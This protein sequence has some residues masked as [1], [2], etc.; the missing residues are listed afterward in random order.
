MP[1]AELER[2]LR[3]LGVE[4]E[5]PA[6]PQL[7]QSVTRHLADAGVESR[8]PRLGWRPL[9]ARTALL[10]VALVLLLAGSVVAAVP[11]ARNALLDLVGL[12]GATVER[13]PA[14]P[15]DVEAKLGIGLGHPTTLESAQ[16]SIA[17]EP[18]L[19]A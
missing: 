6:T 9:S 12:R 13:V 15:D 10:A 14:L 17:F 3:Q 16:G 4:V 7:A 2:R 18:L 19:P 8:R 1:V 11:A 5:Y